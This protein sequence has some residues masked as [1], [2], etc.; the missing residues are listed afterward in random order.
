M[1][2]Y[3]RGRGQG[4]LLSDAQDNVIVLSM[5]SEGKLSH[6]LGIAH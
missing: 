2:L 1:E 5:L 3:H 4:I 6:F